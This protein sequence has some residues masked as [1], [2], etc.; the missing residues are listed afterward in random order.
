[1]NHGKF[2]FF[3]VQFFIIR[4]E[5]CFSACLQSLG[6][7]RLCELPGERHGVDQPQQGARA[8]VRPGHQ[9]P[10]LHQQDL[11]ARVLRAGHRQVLPQHQPLQSGQYFMIL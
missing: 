4:H 11:P 7:E 2:D 9:L 1:M 6:R 5:I 10:P 3:D 8:E